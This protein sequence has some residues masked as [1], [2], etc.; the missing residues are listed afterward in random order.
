MHLDHKTLK[1]KKVMGGTISR[2]FAFDRHSKKWIPVHHKKVG[3]TMQLV[4]YGAVRSGTA[5][6]PIFK[7]A[8]ADSAKMG[9]LLSMMA[10]RI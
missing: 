2:L 10:A 9:Q 6:Q 7:T 1:M 3:G 5:I 8:P 4:P